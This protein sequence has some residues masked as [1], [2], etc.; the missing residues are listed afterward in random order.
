MI[1]RN[2]ARGFTLIELL[3]V[4][5]IIG[6]LASMLLPVVARAKQKARQIQCVAYLKQLGVGCALYCADNDDSL[7]ETSHQGASWIGML[8]QYGLNTVYLCPLDTAHTRVSSHRPHARF[9]LCHQ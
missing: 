1:T 5:A 2:R 4:I 7:P 6:I 3:V 9:Q 8:A